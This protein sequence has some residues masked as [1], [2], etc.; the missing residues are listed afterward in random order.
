MTWACRAA[1]A[2]IFIAA[3]RFGQALAWHAIG[4]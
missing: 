3:F 4:G 2:G 1:W